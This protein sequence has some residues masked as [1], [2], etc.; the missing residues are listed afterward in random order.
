MKLII[1]LG[2]ITIVF[3]VWIEYSVGN[4]FF[5]ISEK[6]YKQMNFLSL[7]NYMVHPFH[8]LFLWNWELL[9]INYLFVLGVSIMLYSF[10]YKI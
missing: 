8:N 4:I 1:F 10:T 6:G 3:I 5:R 7:F 9:D 2:I